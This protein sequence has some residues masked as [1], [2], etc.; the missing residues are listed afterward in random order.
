MQWC[1]IV[2]EYE[3]E[4]QNPKDAY[5]HP[6]LPKQLVVMANIILNDTQ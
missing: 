4:L 1:F 3:L 5:W 2:T 6:F